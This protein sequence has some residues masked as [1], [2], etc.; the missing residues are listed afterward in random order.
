MRPIVSLRD[1]ASRLGT[2]VDRLR[3]IASG[4]RG[5]YKTMPLKDKKNKHVVRELD[6]PSD[7]LKEIQRRIKANILDR[8]GFSTAAHGG[9]RGRSPRTNAMQHLGQRCVVNLDVRHFFPNVRHYVVYRMFRYELGFGHDVARLLTRLTTLKSRLP[10][11][12][13]TSTAVA[14]LVLAL[15]LDRPIEIEAGR[16]GIRVTRFVDDITLSGA[17]PRPLIN[18]VGRLLSQR[19]LPMYRKKARWLTRPKLRISSQASPQEVTGLIVNSKTGPTV[20]KTRRDNI[21]AAVFQLEGLRGEDFAAA[22]RSIRGRISHVRQFNPRAAGR[23]D[24]YLA[25]TVAKAEHA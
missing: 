16:S 10:Q 4:I 11:G 21:R 23:L 15:P 17:D 2:P 6:V 19:R 3:A 13:P 18:R 22:V 9:V 8:I 14:N 24:R 5:D 20:S 7:E 1:L 12:T 25:L